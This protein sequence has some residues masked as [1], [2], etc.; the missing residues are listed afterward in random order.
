MAESTESGDENE[1]A[2]TFIE[3]RLFKQVAEGSEI[4]GRSGFTLS[5]INRQSRL[6]SFSDSAYYPPLAPRAAI[7]R[8]F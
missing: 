8:L 3:E 2:A 4:C 6:P 1:F 5:Q 7:H